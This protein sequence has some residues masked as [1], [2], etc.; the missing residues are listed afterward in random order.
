MLRG[1][2]AF[3]SGEGRPLGLQGEGAVYANAALRRLTSGPRA[4]NFDLRESGDT[5]VAAPPLAKFHGGELTALV[6]TRHLDLV[7]RSLI[8]KMTRLQQRGRLLLLVLIPLHWGAV[9]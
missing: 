4:R 3:A 8:G 6:A 9:E 7:G 1:G 2:L 5:G